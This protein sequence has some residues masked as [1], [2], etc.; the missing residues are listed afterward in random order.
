[1]EPA[2]EALM[3]SALH[4][5][6]NTLSGIR[7]VLEL[8]DPDRPLS[9]R[10]R[11]RLEAVL[12]E[13]M[14]TLERS[15]HLAME[16][17]PATS[18]E[19]GLEWR[20]LLESALNPLATVFRCTLRLHYK[21]SALHDHWPGECLRGHL[22]AMARNLLPYAEAQEIDLIFEADE[23]EWRVIWTPIGTLPPSL[24]ASKTDRSRDIASRWTLQTGAALG[25][26]LSFLE[27]E[28][29]IEIKIPRA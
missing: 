22:A 8:S 7:G 28:R 9:R 4:D 13:G 16:T 25:S 18:L 29:Q 5:L 15:R 26:K 19:P 23:H 27:A 10:D 17:L 2:S 24:D 12:S 11:L 1:M 6:A 20:A 21:G 14:A 3:R